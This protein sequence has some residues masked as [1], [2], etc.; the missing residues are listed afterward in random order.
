MAFP[1][2]AIT[3]VQSPCKGCGERALACHGSCE[4]YAAFRVKCEALAVER[5]HASE[6]CAY[7]DEVLKRMPGLRN[8]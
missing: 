3:L 1:R 2:E 5:Q 4:K 8:L 6:V 7:L